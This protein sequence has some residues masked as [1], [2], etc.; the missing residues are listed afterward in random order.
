MPQQPDLTKEHLW[1]NWLRRIL[2]R[3]SA[4]NFHTTGK[5]YA[6]RGLA[7]TDPFSRAATEA[8][9]RRYPEP[10]G[11]GKMFLCPRLPRRLNDGFQVGKFRREIEQTLRA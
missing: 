11:Q 1:P 8:A 6:E 7:S 10:K 5:S 3:N 9:N 4:F 2:P